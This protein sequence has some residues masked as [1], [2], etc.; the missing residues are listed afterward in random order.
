DRFQLKMHRETRE[1]PVYELVVAKG[2]A[3][4]QLSEDQSPPK[5]PD[6]GAPPPP[7]P[8]RGA[9]PARGSTFIQRTPSGFTMQVTGAS[10]TSFISLLS[11]QTGRPVVDK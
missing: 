7:P 2:G 5:P 8:Q 9:P 6:R 4:V 11:A 10:W 1:L 3:K